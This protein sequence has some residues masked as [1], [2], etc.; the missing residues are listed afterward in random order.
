MIKV[1]FEFDTTADAINAINAVGGLDKAAPKASKPAKP[2]AE[3]LKEAE[4]AKAAEAPAAT[5]PATKAAIDAPDYEKVV[6]PKALEL[7]KA[8]GRD[9]L[10]N[11]YKKYGVEN[12]KDIAPELL[13]QFVDDA[14][15][16]ILV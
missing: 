9:V 5:A 10:V 6:K 8:K 15:D 3:K 1:T 14:N 4:T 12:A 11:L 16:A 13:Q 7:A 2:A